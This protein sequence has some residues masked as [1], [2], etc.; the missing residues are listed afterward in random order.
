MNR[1]LHQ[2]CNWAFALLL[3]S[4]V[5]ALSADTRIAFYEGEEWEARA[6]VVFSPEQIALA[7]GQVDQAV[8]EI[9][10]KMREAGAEAKWDKQQRSEG[11]AYTVTANGVGLETLN[12]AFFDGQ[13][14]LYVDESSG[15]RQIVFSY[16]PGLQFAET[17]T[18]TLV[19]GQIIAANG[20][21]M[22]DRTV[23][24]VNP[25]GTMEAILTEAPRYG[26]LPY[27]LIGVGIVLVI[28]SGIGIAGALLIK[29]RAP[30]IPRAVET[31]PVT[32]TPAPTP[33]PPPGTFCPQCGARL[34]DE[35]VFCPNCGS[36]IA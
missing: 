30:A 5:T 12:T 3:T 32:S 25:A 29:P 24:W 31:I 6:E 35:A 2:L 10:A 18:F 13:A 27:A 20:A 19:G 17:E 8:A 16:Y 34:S 28:V 1:L 15:Q 33:P 22:D 14:T 36:K 21:Q 11:I 26:W 4:C 23:T 9:A 7:G